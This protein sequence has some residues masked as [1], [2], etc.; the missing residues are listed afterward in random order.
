[1][2]RDDHERIAA[3]VNGNL[4]GA[5]QFVE[6][7]ATGHT[8]EHY[9]NQQAAFAF[10]ASPFDPSPGKMIGDWLQQHR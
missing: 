9:A 10:K 5:A 7:P 1:M 2:S 8:F 6:L 4:T 3:L